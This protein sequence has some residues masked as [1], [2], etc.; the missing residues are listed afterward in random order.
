MYEKFFGLSDLP[1]SIAPN[2]RYLYMS[3]HHNEALAHLLY[4]VKQDGGFILLTGEVGTG[5][6]TVCR[7]FLEKLPENCHVAVILNPKLTID[8]L[9]ETLCD[10]LG[11]AYVQDSI[12]VKGYLDV[13]NQF[14]LKAHAKH[15]KVL[16]IID[17]AQNL[18][19]DVLEQIRLLT[20]LETDQR[21]LLQIVLIGQP[22]LRALFEQ[23]V[24]RQLAQ[25]ITA[26]Y[27]LPHLSLPETDAYIRHRLDVAG[28]SYELFPTS[29]V[30]IIFKLTDGIPRLINVMCDRALLG[31]YVSGQRY[32][33][34][35]IMR[36]AAREL[37]T[38]KRFFS[39]EFW[40]HYH[41]QL[42]LKV[43]LALL[44]FVVALLAGI[45]QA[46]KYGQSISNLAPA[47]PRPT[48]L[49]SIVAG[50]AKPLAK[51]PSIVGLPVKPGD[52][53]LKQ[54]DQYPVAELERQLALMEKKSPPVM[55]ALSLDS[56]WQANWPLTADFASALHFLY[57]QWGGVPNV[58][59]LNLES[60][61]RPDNSRLQCL[62]Q[63]GASISD[64]QQLPLP[65]MLTLTKP[66]TNA[67][68]Y[69]VVTDFTDS[70]L[71]LEINPV[72]T[73]RSGL[74]SSDLKGIHLGF[75]ELSRY[76][77]GQYTLVWQVPPGY[78]GPIVPGTIGP[79]VKWLSQQLGE[80]YNDPQL[81][82]GASIF[83]EVLLKN[84][85][86]FQAQVGLKPD[87]IVGP[88][89]LVQLYRALKLQQDKTNTQQPN[90]R[91]G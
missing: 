3:Q 89:T 74:S 13:L 67:P 18:S 54:V 53:K 58:S 22:E 38:H 72:A 42:K 83:N 28:C 90:Q 31:A 11:I 8:E 81:K 7:C 10:E 20:N 78:Y 25:R 60:C 76:W 37:M 19:I 61:Q 4:G 59:D 24:L 49:A 34:K 17:E 91:G 66:G 23:K 82:N 5:K 15:T 87:G 77:Q 48:A 1:F 43:T 79:G 44:F 86:K 29:V 70:E 50:H 69:G 65:F 75:K 6:T 39:T 14:L 36:Q 46:V 51:E 45:V 2:P 55:Q 57:M 40:K 35:N 52:R 62:Q 85:K 63:D 30:R 88:T 26:R 9:L 21:K 16:L 41:W 80:L 84:V 32:V 33:D 47:S 56:L 71:T 12:S 64:I 27:H 68:F 73:K